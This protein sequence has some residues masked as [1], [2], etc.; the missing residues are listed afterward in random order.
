MMYHYLLYPNISGEQACVLLESR[1]IASSGYLDKRVRQHSGTLALPS[2]VLQI[3]DWPH[4]VLYTSSDESKRFGTKLHSKSACRLVVS[5]S[6]LLLRK[7]RSYIEL[8]DFFC[9]V[10]IQVFV[11][12]ISRFGSQLQCNDRTAKTGCLVL[13]REFA[14]LVGTSGSS[15]AETVTDGP[16]PQ[17]ICSIWPY[18]HRF[19]TTYV[20]NLAAARCSQ[21]CSQLRS[22]LRNLLLFNASCSLT[23]PF[24]IPHFKKLLKARSRLCRRL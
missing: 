16:K 24:R 6:V 21:P 17:I 8:P 19:K 13:A 3:T 15:G 4:N 9:F 11:H 20:G 14:M 22:Q 18:I 2:N 23:L 12:L 1:T 7:S 10:G 5:N